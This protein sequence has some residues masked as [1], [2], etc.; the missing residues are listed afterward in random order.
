[1][2]RRTRQMRDGRLQG[3]EAI[4]QRQQ[5]VRPDS[6]NGRLLRLGQDRQ[7]RFRRPGLET[8]DRLAFAPLRHR[9]VV[10]PQLPAQRRERSLR[11]FGLA[12]GPIA[13][14]PS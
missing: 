13:G 8:L 1:M 11:S 2:P 3:I 5:R 14:Q 7:A 4:V 10:N 6:N 9:L 12:L